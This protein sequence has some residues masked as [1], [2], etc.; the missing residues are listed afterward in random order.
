MTIDLKE[1][2]E[3]YGEGCKCRCHTDDS[4]YCESCCDGY[5]DQ[6]LPA[7]V[8]LVREVR[9]MILDRIAYCEPGSPNHIAYSTWL[10]KVEDK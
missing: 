3:R 4:V 8:A 5:N 2:E 9:E 1:I 7:L 6:D 10:A